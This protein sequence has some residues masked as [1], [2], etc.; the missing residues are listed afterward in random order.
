MLNNLDKE[1]GVH[2]RSYNNKHV[3]VYYYTY[4]YILLFMS[5]LVVYYIPFLEAKIFTIFMN[6]QDKYL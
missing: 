2:D 6:V 5:M 3:R 1:K 4:I